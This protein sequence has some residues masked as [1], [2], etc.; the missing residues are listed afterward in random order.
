MA[1]QPIDTAP[2]DGTWILLRGRN[3]VGVPMIPIVAAWNP[4]GSKHFGWVDSG[5]F[6]PS[7]NLAADAGA[8]WAPLPE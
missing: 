2:K 3:A 1:Y 8:D 6:K 4:A 5:S 7:D